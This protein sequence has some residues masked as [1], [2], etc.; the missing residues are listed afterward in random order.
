MHNAC[1]MQVNLEVLEVLVL[2]LLS[3]SKMK[4]KIHMPTFA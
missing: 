2:L 4:P 3:G 1:L